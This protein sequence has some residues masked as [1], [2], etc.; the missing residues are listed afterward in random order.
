MYDTSIITHAHVV[1]FLDGGVFVQVETFFK[2]HGILEG[3]IV[4]E[5]FLWTRDECPCQLR[6]VGRVAFVV[7]LAFFY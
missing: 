2:V 6:G 7:K 5:T 4:F 3:G 1:E